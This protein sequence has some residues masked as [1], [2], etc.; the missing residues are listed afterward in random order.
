VIT[1]DIPES[2]DGKKLQVEIYNLLGQR[3]YTLLSETVSPGRINLR[4]DGRDAD[5]NS[6]ASGVYFLRVRV[7]GVDEVRKMMLMK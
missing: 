6:L 5:N 1:I 4:W 7:G 3:V 2:S